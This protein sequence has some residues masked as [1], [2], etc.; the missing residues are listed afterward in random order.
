MVFDI[1]ITD[2]DDIRV[3][4][5]DK[6][7]CKRCWGLI[8]VAVKVLDSTLRDDFGFKHLL[9]VYSGRRGIHLWISDSEAFNLTDECRR[10]L[11]GWLE[12]IKGSG[13]SLKKVNAGSI[14][15]TH[16]RTLH[17]SLKRA[18]GDDEKSGPLKDAFVE[19]ILKDQNCF[20]ERKHWETLLDLLPTN[21]SNGD[22][23]IISRLRTK[24]EK[25]PTR[26]SLE[27]WGDIMNEMNK[28]KKERQNVWKPHLEDIILQYTYPRIDSEVS[29][30]M[31]HL[32]KS[33]FVVHPSTGN[34]CIPLNVEM[35][36][37]FDP[38][39]DCPTVGM[40]LREFNKNSNKGEEIRKGMEWEKTSLKPYVEI[41]DRYCAGIIKETRAAKKGELNRMVVL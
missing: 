24:W 7:I 39:K 20:R 22:L 37:D 41:L 18:L 35:I 25:D 28:I 26:R 17:P 32:L 12:I 33:P 21:Q 40:V 8:A 15:P 38:L 19:V 31:N 10:S 23:E 9:W 5:S 1:D 11:V 6:A 16:G 2:Y 4:C 29:K 27:K 13:K 34:V 30:K 3:C 36:Q 14:N